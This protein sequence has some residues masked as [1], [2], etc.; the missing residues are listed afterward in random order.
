MS[1]SEWIIKK[2]IETRENVEQMVKNP[3]YELDEVVVKDILKI[4]FPTGLLMN[5][6]K[7]NITFAVYFM[8]LAHRKNFVLPIDFIK[9]MKLCLNCNAAI[10]ETNQDGVYHDNVVLFSGFIGNF[11]EYR[12]LTRSVTKEKLE[13]VWRVNE[14]IFRFIQVMKDMPEEMSIDAQKGFL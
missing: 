5:N 13:W 6:I 7:T 9:I 4:L 1:F 10:Y 8:T 12:K 2:K 14:D 3:E 11:T